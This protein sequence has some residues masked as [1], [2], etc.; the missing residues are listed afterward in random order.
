M[1]ELSLHILE[2]RDYNVEEFGLARI[3]SARVLVTHVADDLAQC[4]IALQLFTL[5]AQIVAE[6]AQ[7]NWTERERLL[8]SLFKLRRTVHQ[9]FIRLTV[10]NRKHVCQFVA[11][12]LIQ[13]FFRYLP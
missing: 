12:S 11:C 2:L 6:L 13:L 4:A 1:R 3:V 10:T 5:E 9:A 8:I 7:A